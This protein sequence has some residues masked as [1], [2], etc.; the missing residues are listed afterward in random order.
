MLREKGFPSGAYG[1]IMVTQNG[2]KTI[3][4]TLNSIMDQTLQ[5]TILCVV[6][7]GVSYLRRFEAIRLEKQERRLIALMRRL[8]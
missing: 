6:D 4:F 7:D 2:A 1:V 8:I 3:P 5:P